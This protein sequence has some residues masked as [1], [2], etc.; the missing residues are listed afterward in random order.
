MTSTFTDDLQTPVL[1]IA[2]P[3][4]A[5]ARAP[6]WSAVDAAT[7]DAAEENLRKMG[8]KVIEAANT[9]RIHERFAGTD[10]ERAQGVMEV[11][12]DPEV[13]LVMALRGGYG[14]A[15]ILPLLDWEKIQEFSAPL[16]GLSDITAL[17]LALLSRTGRPSWQG[18]TLTRF[19]TDDAFCSSHFSRA[20]IEE[21]WQLTF[22]PQRAPEKLTL[23]GTLWGGN[24]SILV[25]LIGTPWLPEI[26]D[27]ILYLEDIGEPAWRVERMLDQLAN[28]GILGTQKAIVCGEFLDA[29]RS[30]GDGDGRFT[31]ADAL[32]WIEDKTGVPV[33]T[34]LPFGHQAATATIPN[35]VA[36]QL[37][38][39]EKTARLSSKKPPLPACA[40][41]LTRPHAGL[42]W[43]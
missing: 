40:P 33:I 34:G 13:D 29:D 17:E 19:A 26:V 2:A 39:E 27:G 30:A 5:V 38:V 9:R 12:C 32:S 21:E 8:W 23:Q 1:A 14:T 11:L 16:I 20:M 22:T 3:A 43:E 35:G 37:T 36:A 28:C 25:S 41:G 4:R 7:I 31:L 18:P 6:H 15:R 42:W 24:L 10:R